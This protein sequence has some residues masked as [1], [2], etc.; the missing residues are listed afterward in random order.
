MT[1]RIKIP[2]RNGKLYALYDESSQPKPTLG[3]LL[4]HSWPGL[5][6]S[7]R[8]PVLRAISKSLI[9]RGATVLRIKFRRVNRDANMWQRLWASGQADIRA[10]RRFLRDRLREQEDGDTIPIV[11]AG[12]SYG[13]YQMMAAAHRRDNYHALALVAPPLR[14][15]RQR[16]HANSGPPTLIV[17]SDGDV[18]CPPGAVKRLQKR[19]PDS[20]TSYILEGT[21]H[22]LK[23]RV[24]EVA[25]VVEEF[26]FAP[27]PA[28][29]HR[30]DPT[31]VTSSESN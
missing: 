20:I 23:G 13:A 15:S 4:C 17:T 21:D 16:L 27:H 10:G 2:T 3:V 26:L 30:D 22:F 31:Y 18:Y 24:D 14:Y 28:R 12:Y 29:E 8:E 5:G 11:G 9:E 7:V 6:G 25:G 1:N 19:R